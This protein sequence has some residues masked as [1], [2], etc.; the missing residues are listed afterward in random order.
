MSAV[1]KMDGVIGNRKP[2]MQRPEPFGEVAAV[3]HDGGEAC[4]IHVKAARVHVQ[5]DACLDQGRR[6]GPVSFFKEPEV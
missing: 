5:A 1:Q 6:Q 2:T 4:C 3:Q